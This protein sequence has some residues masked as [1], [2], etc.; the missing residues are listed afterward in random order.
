MAQM[1]RTNS[2]PASPRSGTRLVGNPGYRAYLAEFAA[3]LLPRVAAIGARIDVTVEAVRHDYV[4]IRRISRDPIHDRIRL[5]RQRARVPMLAP[6]ARALNRATLA[7]YEIAIANENRIRIAGPKCDSP[8]IR[9]RITL[10]EA[11][12]LVQGPLLAAI[13]AAPDAVRS[14]G[15]ER[16]RVGAQGHAV[17]IGIEHL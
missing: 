2:R 14:G 5:D 16:L 6:I 10:G 17:D 12:K 8:A 9:N 4:G 13:R 1:G 11:R 3:V 15:V 7:R